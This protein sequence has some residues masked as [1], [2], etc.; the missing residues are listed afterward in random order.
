MPHVTIEYSKNLEHE[1]ELPKL[2]HDIH[3][4]LIGCPGIDMSRVKT[5]LHSCNS[6]LNETDAREVKMIH[7][8]LAILSGRNNAEKK[9]CGEKLF[10]ALK[11]NIPE[12]IVSNTALSVEVRDMDRDNYFR[13]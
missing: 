13:S 4:S 9:T 11:Q 7:V 8:T 6:V 1:V 3:T 2:L 12:K 10:A 5:R